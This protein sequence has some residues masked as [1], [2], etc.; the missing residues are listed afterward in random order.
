MKIKIFL[1]LLVSGVIFTACNKDD[2]PVTPLNPNNAEKAFIDRFSEDAGNLFVRNSSNNLPAANQAINF[3]EGPFI[4]TGLGPDGE[5]VEYYN[6]DV[7]PITPAPIYILFK[8]GESTPVADQLNI[9]DV[10]PGDE[11]YNDFWLVNRVTVPSNYVANTVT[12]VEGIMAEDY[13]IE[14][15]ET[16]VNCP[17]VPD[18]ST[19]SKR[20]GNGEEPGLIQGWYKDMLVYYFTF[21]EKSLVSTSMGSQ[22]AVPVSGI[23]VTFNVN[24]DMAGGGPTSGFA[25]EGSTL[26]THNVIETL[27]T[28]DAYSP[29]WSVS[30]YDNAFFNSVYDWPSAM[31]ATV[32][33]ANVAL[34]NCPV[35]S[36]D[37]GNPPMDPDMAAKSS[38]DRFSDAAATL[39]VRNGKNNFP[40]PNMPVN[41]DEEP[42]ITKGLGPNGEMVEY[43]N[44]D[45]MPTKPAPIYLFFREGEDSPVEGQLN[46]L[47]VIPGDEGYSDFW[48]VHHVIVPDY[49]IAN[50]VTSLDEINARG[51]TVEATETI[52]NC[53][54]VPDGSTASKRFSPDED[55]ELHQGWYHDQVIYY[56]NFFEKILTAEYVNDETSVP[57]S[58]I[59]V[60]FNINPGMEGGGPASGFV[61]E[62][63]SMQTHNTVETLPNDDEY[64]PLWYINV[65][66]NNDFET[67]MDWESAKTANLLVAGAGLANCPV[68]KVN[69]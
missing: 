53:P 69:P 18:G 19:A 4:T 61:T 27:P 13:A 60:T 23:L 14:P 50:S 65:Y 10:I 37:D 22:A 47:D 57:L 6:F 26:Q 32:L 16:I 68:V 64:S 62:N 7:Q 5:M 21:S 51:Y 12:S 55:T 67:V 35:V 38:V 9:I 59:Y 1:I 48:H 63:G 41:F 8:E 36:V 29:L 43:Y 39:F 33:G 44:F 56:F 28:D 49:Y 3:D 45:I 20:F 58:D 54:V 42:F 17:V 40:G 25:T 52:V 31:E 30:A 24:P 66:D 11:G 2:E 46:V 15:T 34:V